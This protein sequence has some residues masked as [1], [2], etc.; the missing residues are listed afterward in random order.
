MASRLSQAGYSSEESSSRASLFLQV[1]T[2][3]VVFI[4][5]LRDDTFGFEIRS[6]QEFMAGEWIVEQLEK[7]EVSAFHDIGMS[8]YWRNTLLFAIGKIFAERE[9]LCGEVIALC[10]DLN[11]RGTA[12]RLATPGSELALSVLTEGVA[13]TVP[14]YARPLAACACKA[15]SAGSPAVGLLADLD[16]LGVREVLDPELDSAAHGSA[17]AQ[18]SAATVLAHR[19]L[20]SDQEA[21]RALR[22]IIENMTSVTRSQLISLACAMGL[23]PILDIIGNGIFEESPLAVLNH[24]GY[25]AVNIWP[26]TA[27]AN[28]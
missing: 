10:D 21:P 12:A 25:D 8:S 16:Q 26:S 7:K 1:F 22:R 3:R 4:T 9:H 5:E 11:V 27:A 18:I 14:R 24:R 23:D 28:R 19:A 15:L 2:D 20:R 6:L 13:L 17:I